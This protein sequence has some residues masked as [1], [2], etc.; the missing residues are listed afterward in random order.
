MWALRTLDNPNKDFWDDKKLDNKYIIPINKILDSYFKIDK[1]SKPIK[2][3]SCFNG[4]G[5]YRYNDIIGCSYN[6]DITCEH[7]QFHKEMIK[8][9]NAKLYIYPKLIV[10][11]H[12]ILGKPMDKC[13]IVKLVK[14]KL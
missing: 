4:I 2:V 1:E 11:P 12:K 6:G 7:I 10:G 3:H 14:N 8:K 13:N 9:Y 5:I